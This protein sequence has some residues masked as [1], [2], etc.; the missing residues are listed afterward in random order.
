MT[1]ILLYTIA[2]ILLYLLTDAALRALERLHGE[3]IPYRNWVFFVLILVLAI[4]L[5]QVL[6]LLLVGDS[7]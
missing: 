3:P 6:R 2:G 1:E 7:T 4:I 5:F